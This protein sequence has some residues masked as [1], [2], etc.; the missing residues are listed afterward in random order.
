MPHHFKFEIIIFAVGWGHWRLQYI[1]YS[2]HPLEATVFHG[3]RRVPRLIPISTS[4]LFVFAIV[5]FWFLLYFNV[6][7][8]P[9]AD[10]D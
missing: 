8:S 3:G 9:F 2:V 5:L 7:A 1:V 4:P 10:I 6:V